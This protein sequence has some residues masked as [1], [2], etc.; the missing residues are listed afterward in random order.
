MKWILVPIVALV[1]IGLLVTI[2]GLTLPLGHVASR[3]A[4]FRQNPAT[5][6]DAISAPAEWRSDVVRTESLPA[7]NGRERWKEFGKHGDGVTYELIESTRPIRR[8]TRIADENLPY[9]GVWTLEIAPAA[10][11]STVAITERG[12]VSN[13]I[14]RFVSRFVIGHHRTIDTYLADLAKKLGEPLQIEK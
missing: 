10:G 6:F 3:R 11:G 2:I 9:G 13:P 5:V 1:A 4:R 8:V 7:V 14:F 12:E